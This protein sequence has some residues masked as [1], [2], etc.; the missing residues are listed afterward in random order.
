MIFISDILYGLMLYQR[1]KT[2]D[3]KILLKN[4]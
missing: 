3:V 2:I 4:I 1:E